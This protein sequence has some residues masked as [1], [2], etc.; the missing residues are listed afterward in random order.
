MVLRKILEFA[1]SCEGNISHNGTNIV[2][3]LNNGRPLA[4][5]WA[6]K[7]IPVIPEAW[8]LGSKSGNEIATIETISAEDVAKLAED[9]ELNIFDVRKESEYLSEHVVNAR[10]T[11]LDS[12]NDYLAEY[13]T[14]G[15][16]YTHCAG[17]YRSVIANSILKSR[18]IHNLIDVLGG[19]GAIKNTEIEK[20]DYVCPSTL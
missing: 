16:N 14:E 18:G 9:K 17:G 3:V 19:Y 2:L 15:V 7:N 5:E 20:T 6:S 13:K 12:I 11:P 1:L 8:K 4:I 10:N